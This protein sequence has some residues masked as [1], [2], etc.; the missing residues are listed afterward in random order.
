[1]QSLPVPDKT[2]E[3]PPVPSISIGDNQE[4][5]IDLDDHRT[6]PNSMP[7]AETFS[8]SPGAR[9]GTLGSI[10]GQDFA[11]GDP[12][13]NELA[14]VD[15][16]TALPIDGTAAHPRH[17]ASSPVAR[18]GTN[19]RAKP[20]ASRDSSSSRSTSPSPPN[21]VHAFANSRPRGRAGTM[22]SRRSSIDTLHR[23]ISG[24]THSRR[25]T[26]SGRDQEGMRPDEEA[27]E[28]VCYPHPERE[29]RNSE[30]SI[31]FEEL[32]EFVQ[33][34]EDEQITARDD[35]STARRKH[36]A[37][38]RGS[39]PGILQEGS[40][41]E[42]LEKHQHTSRA[43]S[44]ASK[45]ASKVEIAN[46]KRWYTFFSSELDDTIHAT[47]IGGLLE[48]G[49]TFQHLFELGPDSGCWWLDSLNATE[50]EVTALCKA[51]GVHPLTREDIVTGE[52][53]EKVELFSQYYF[54]SFRSYDND[55][56]SEDYLEPMSV[57]AVVF[58]QG[59]LTFTFQ[60]NPHT[61]N[62]LK[63]ISRLRDYMD[64]S[65]DWICYAL[66]DDIVDSFLPP[67]RD[68]E[69]EVDS[70]EDQVF[71]AREE[72]A[73]PILRAIADC[74]KK[75]M[76]ILRLLGSKP[77]VIKGFAKRCNEQYS[78]A[79]RGDVGMYLS[80]IQDHVVTYRD[81]LSHSEQLLSRLHNNFLAQINVDHISQ[82]NRVNKILGK[83][84][85]IATIIVPLNLVTGLFGMNVPVPGGVGES[86][87]YAWFGGIVAF[88]FAF[89]FCGYCVAKRLR[90]F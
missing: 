63:R 83:V 6:Q 27:E 74:R 15:D 10:Y 55:K 60:Q 12:A 58:K 70:I 4:P 43:S 32:E 34:Q 67:I 28:D 42:D 40:S 1:M 62:V 73:R 2:E 48:E 64:L 16:D 26:F 45:R 29:R 36:E 41:L 77:D 86:H 39:Q 82:G 80:D 79:P 72:D 61:K 18:R 88:L 19:R 49:E 38:A 85:L 50:D 84:T 9:R 46:V 30:H 59:L 51:F 13:L 8:R 81:N 53:R 31:D 66:I 90:L 33:E 37:P 54:V 76:S 78:A 75:A 57:Y 22:T 35:N 20:N 14:I 3:T 56:K 68:I 69:V 21:S 52:S 44:I 11:L 65:A 47:S 71:S 87:N 17:G 24:G 5:V 23:T 7:R 89:V 25:P